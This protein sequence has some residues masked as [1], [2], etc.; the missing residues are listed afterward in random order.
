MLLARPAFTAIADEP[1]PERQV[2]M[3]ASLIAQTMERLA[4]IWVAYR[5]ASATDPKA[6]ANLVAAHRRRHETFAAMVGM[7]PEDRLRQSLEDSTD[8]AWAIGSIDVFLLL[9]DL[10]GWDAEHYTAWLR[11]TLMNALL[12]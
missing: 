8:T 3:A 1:E 7:L 6:A 9:R 5:E 10:Q 12:V 11:R 2:E 4:P